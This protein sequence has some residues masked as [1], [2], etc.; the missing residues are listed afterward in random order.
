MVRGATGELYHRTRKPV[1]VTE[2]RSDS[3]GGQRPVSRPQVNKT[4]LDSPEDDSATILDQIDEV[5]RSS[6]PPPQN[7]WKCKKK[8]EISLFKF[9]NHFVLFEKDEISLRQK[10]ETWILKLFQVLF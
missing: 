3:T 10:L 2:D 1:E 8:I 6:T 7:S 9:L 4:I 5:I